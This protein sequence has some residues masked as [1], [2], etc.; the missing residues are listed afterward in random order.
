MPKKKSNDDDI[1]ELDDEEEEIDDVEEEVKIGW[2][3]FY[4]YLDKNYCHLIPL[5]NISRDYI[6]I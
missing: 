4:C 6:E 3:L 5:V 1:I 2:K